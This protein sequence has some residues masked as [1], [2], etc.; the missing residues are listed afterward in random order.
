MKRDHK[1]MLAIIQS[2]PVSPGIAARDPIGLLVTDHPRSS[3]TVTADW[4][5]G[6]DIPIALREPYLG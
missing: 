3:D 2:T 1:E 4:G 6:L 5:P